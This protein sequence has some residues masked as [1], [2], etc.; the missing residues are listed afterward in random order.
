MRV[1][2]VRSTAGI[3]GGGIFQYELAFLEALSEFAPRFAGEFLYLT[4][5]QSDLAALAHFGGLNYRG[6]TIRMLDQPRPQQ[7]PPEA[8]LKLQPTALPPSP[9]PDQVYFDRKGANLLR[10][11]DIDLI[12]Q[13]SPVANA[14]SLRLPFVVPIFDLNHRLQPE[15]PE[16]SAFGESERREYFYINACRFATL[17]LV[18]SEVSKDDV[19]RFYGEFIG[20]DRIRILPYFPPIVRN[21]VPG[22]QECARVRERYHLPK[23]Y[24][25][26][27]AQFWRHK[28]HALILRAIRLIG[29]ENGEA[30]HVVFCGAY[31]DYHR[32]A[33][34][35]DIMALVEELGIGD[36]VHYL[37]ILPEE[38]IPA[39]YV[40]SVGL[41]MPTFFGPTNIPPF[42][43]WH[44]GRPVICS[45]IRG[46]REQIGDAGLLV[47]PLSPASLAQ[48]MLNVW[49]EGSFRE[50]LIAAGRQRL[51]SFTW[52][53]FSSGVGDIVVEACERVRSGR[54]PSYPDV[55]HPGNLGNG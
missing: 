53:S 3:S 12:L 46:V 9:D 23:R 1:G 4:A 10:D 6:L 15:F 2:I 5:R 13:L 31:S 24:F 21:P 14:F 49:Q 22:P 37:G 47:D 51:A 50:R 16:V 33:N 55:L 26:Y 41:V 8:Y 30:L 44:Y 19:L 48:A 11:V 40:A 20:D 28:N 38:E 7:L 52:S 35:K 45:D 17:V 54:T 34:F 36:R 42:E 29:D 32:A 18:D 27:P 43:A 25:F 39:L